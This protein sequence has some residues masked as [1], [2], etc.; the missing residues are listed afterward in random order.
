MPLWG[1]LFVPGYDSQSLVGEAPH[2]LEFWYDAV[3]ECD[4]PGVEIDGQP[5]HSPMCLSAGPHVIRVLD[6]EPSRVVARRGVS[7]PRIELPPDRPGERE[8]LYQ[9]W[10]YRRIL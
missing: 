10:S 2:S 9:D 6:A 7:P 5:F 4:T 8:F 3:Y 1:L